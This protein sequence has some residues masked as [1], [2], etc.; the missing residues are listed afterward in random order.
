MIE[1]YVSP[2]E[3]RRLFSALLVVIVFIAL[4]AVFGFLV[5]PGMRNANQPSPGAPLSGGA[6]V[7]GWLDP[8]D[9]PPERGRTIPPI[10]PATVMTP[11]PALLARGQA[12]FNSTCTSCHGPKGEGDGAAGRGLNPPPRNFT[13]NEG[14]QNGPRIDSIYKTL[15]EGIKG[16]SMVSYSYLSKR[17]RMALVHYVRSL[18]SFDHGPER[19][20]ALEALAKLFRTAGEVLPNRIPV[21]M[22]MAKL[23]QEY[24][25][26]AGF[27]PSRDPV[28]GQAVAD[29]VRAAQALAE[30]P[31]WRAS[32]QALAAA[33]VPGVPANG[34]RP[35]VALYTPG[36]WQDLR[37][38]L[39]RA[40]KEEAP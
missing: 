8:T 34:F 12:L 28:L 9:Y 16:S 18:G 31:G 13:K 10:D 23:E 24:Q 6:G 37:K 7:T 5:V 36:Q 11:N 1:R 33:V 21:A 14:W 4:M 32:D 40:M 25:A 19:P 22:A 3:L 20:E 26:P 38:A 2:A 29:P 35:E 30:L 39:D 17:D 27:D 15:E